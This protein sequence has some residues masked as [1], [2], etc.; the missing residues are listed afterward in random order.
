[1]CVSQSLAVIDFTAQ[2]VGQRLKYE[3]HAA[4][5]RVRQCLRGEGIKFL[6]AMKL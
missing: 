1:M 3:G 4:S 2:T 5:R 6:N